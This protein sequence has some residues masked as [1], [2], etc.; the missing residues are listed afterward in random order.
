MHFEVIH[1]MN[2][3][4]V[5]SSLFFSTFI[6]SSPT[7]AT[8]TPSLIFFYFQF[9]PAWAL[10]CCSQP[11]CVV[12]QQ[13]ASSFLFHKFSN[14]PP[15]PV[16]CW[17]WLSL[18]C[19][20]RLY[21]ISW[22]AQLRSSPTITTGIDGTINAIGCSLPSRF[23]HQAPV[24]PPSIAR[25]DLLPW[26]KLQNLSI[27]LFRP[28]LSSLIRPLVFGRIPSLLTPSQDCAQW[29]SVARDIRNLAS[30]PPQ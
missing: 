18:T 7:T 22:L 9:P 24:K 29:R 12:S 26:L 4:V 16:P 6:S 21:P 3:L 20:C 27:H 13:R 30:L 10:F 1:L 2:K 14:S 19:Q 5:F 28:N 11:S 15:P 23:P 8:F 25:S 17:R